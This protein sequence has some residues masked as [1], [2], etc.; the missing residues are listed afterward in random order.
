M[1]SLDTLNFENTPDEVLV[2]SHVAGALTTGGRVR[3]IPSHSVSAV[4]CCDDCRRRT[5][6]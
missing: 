6:P 5:R 3:S 2:L 1:L 4:T